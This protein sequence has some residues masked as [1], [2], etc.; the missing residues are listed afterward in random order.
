MTDPSK[1][2]RLLELR[3]HEEARRTAELA[4][5]RQAVSD[6]EL[7]L[8]KL[9]EQRSAAQNMSRDL[10]G[11][12]VGA[13]KTIR[14]LL[15]QIDQGIQNANTVRALA[16]ATVTD[17]EDQLREAEQRRDTLERIVVPRHEHARILKRM[18]EQKVEDEAA[19]T[20]FRSHRR[21]AS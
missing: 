6:A 7:A 5:A 17:K 9:A 11:E 21:S 16:A 12:S 3:R 13:L 4:L 14:M 8:H 10:G 1:L 2:D 20:Q 19:L 15:E 18:A